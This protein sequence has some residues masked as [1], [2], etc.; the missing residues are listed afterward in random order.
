MYRQEQTLETRTNETLEMA[1]RLEP[2]FRDRGRANLRVDS[3]TSN[4]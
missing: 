4:N 2:G 3:L 1:S